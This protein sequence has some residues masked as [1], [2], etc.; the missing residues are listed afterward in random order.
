M[1]IK[2]LPLGTFP[3]DFIFRMVFLGQNYDRQKS[4]QYVK[5]KE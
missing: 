5:V 1:E 2:P 4:V 3:V